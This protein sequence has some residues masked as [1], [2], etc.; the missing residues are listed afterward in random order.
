MNDKNIHSGHRQRLIHKIL[1]GG[2]DAVEQHEMLEAILFLCYR[3]QDT[4]EIAHA[5]LREFGSIYNVCAAPA[6]E[7]VRVDGVGIRTAEH[8]NLF[9]EFVKAYETSFF[10][11]KREFVDMDEMARYCIA[12]QMGNADEVVYVL[13]LDAK[14]RLVKQC[15]IA[16]GNPG[17]V[18]IDTRQVLEAVAHTAAVK[19]VL[20]HNHPGGTLFPS[21]KDLEVT[22]QVRVMLEGIGVKLQDHI[23]V[24]K[25]Q[26]IS[27]YGTVAKF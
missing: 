17:M 4:N 3:Q 25:D 18:H 14:N 7:L 6:G 1:N 9:A 27:C 22:A 24:A 23:I 8:L 19:V 20:C 5:L 16:Q 21:Q 15:R 12:L 26:S 11:P 2:F 13:G 10:A